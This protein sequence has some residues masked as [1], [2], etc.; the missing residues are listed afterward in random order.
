M[1]NYRN[2]MHW[3]E[4]DQKFGLKKLPQR[5]TKVEKFHYPNLSKSKINENDYITVGKGV[6]WPKPVLKKNKNGYKIAL[7]DLYTSLNSFK[8]LFKS[9]LYQQLAQN[10]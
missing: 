6:D 4:I 2:P 1:N 5:I 7:F 3:K 8:I 10:N 9:L